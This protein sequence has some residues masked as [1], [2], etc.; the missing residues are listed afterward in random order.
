MD[1]N[2]KSHYLGGMGNLRHM[3]AISVAAKSEYKGDKVNNISL[4]T[5]IC[6]SVFIAY[7]RKIPALNPCQ[8]MPFVI[9]FI[10]L[11]SLVL[12]TIKPR[13][14]R[15][16]GETIPVKLQSSCL[17]FLNPP[18]VKGLV[19]CSQSITLPSSIFLATLVYMS[20][21]TKET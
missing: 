8:L 13:A 12:P 11:C 7:L 4:F 2:W 6:L 21:T 19:S 17:S 10:S 18:M 1:L 9:L 3:S 20:A 16:L 15:I 14:F 5:S